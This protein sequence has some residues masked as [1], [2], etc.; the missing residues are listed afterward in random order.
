MNNIIPWQERPF[1]IANLLNPAFCSIILWHVIVNNNKKTNNGFDYALTFLVIP[2]I[3][4]KQT[5]ELLPPSTRSKMHVWLQSNQEVL[6]GLDEKIYMLKNITR[7]AVI[8]GLQSDILDVDSEGKLVAK[9]VVLKKY[10]VRST[11]VA[12][13]IE[14]ATMLGKWLAN[15]GD[16]STIVSMWRIKI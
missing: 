5:R 11:E 16:A 8:F 1:E 3:L 14:K 4:A 7:E 9:K 6:I 10:A 12:Q 15:S 2:L 13:C